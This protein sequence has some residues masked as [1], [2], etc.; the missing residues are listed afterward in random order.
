MG[1]PG[2]FTA[3]ADARRRLGRDIPNLF[4]AG[5][6]T[7]LPSING[8]LASGVAA[9]EEVLDLFRVREEP[10]VRGLPA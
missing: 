2:M 1:P 10:Q 4:L 5:D 3:V 8:A 9:G 7:R 6:Y